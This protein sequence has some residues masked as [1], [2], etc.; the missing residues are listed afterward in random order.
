MNGKTQKK[1]RWR[2]YAKRTAWCL[3]T[4]I[5]LYNIL[6][7]SYAFVHW[8]LPG[9]SLLPGMSVSAREVKLHLFRSGNNL[10]IKDLRIIFDKDLSI[11]AAQLKARVDLWKLLHGEIEADEASLAHTTVVAA[12]YPEAL[13][14]ALAEDHTSNRLQVHS[15]RINELT[16]RYTPPGTTSYARLYIDELDMKKIQLDTENEFTFKSALVWHLQGSD[17]LRFPLN[18]KLFCRFGKDAVPVHMRAEIESEAPQGSLYDAELKDLRIR[19]SFE[20]E[21]AKDNPMRILLTNLDFGLWYLNTPVF[22]AKATGFYDLEHDD[23]AC[24]VSVAAKNDSPIF[25][26][27]IL[28]HQVLPSG[29]DLKGEASIEKHG[30]KLSAEASIDARADALSI[31]GKAVMGMAGLQARTSCSAN[32]RE[33]IFQVDKLELTGIGEGREN[34]KLNTE[35]AFVFRHPAEQSWILEANNA[36]LKFKITDFPLKT[37]NQLLPFDLE[38]GTFS[39]DYE[40]KADSTSQKV[41]GFFN[42]QALQVALRHEHGPLTRPAD[43]SFQSN[44]N[45]LGLNDIREFTIP[46]FRMVLTHDGQTVSEY[47][48]GG[49]YLFREKWIELD[50]NMTSKACLLLDLFRPKGFQAIRRKMENFCGREQ[51]N[52]YAVKMKVSIPDRKLDFSGTTHVG[53]PRVLGEKYRGQLIRIGYRGSAVF[54]TDFQ[55]IELEDFSVSLPGQLDLRLKTDAFFP[56][57]EYT[58]SF[59]LKEWRKGIT[60]SLIRVLEVDDPDMPELLRKLDFDNF[61]GHGSFRYNNAAGSLAIDTFDLALQLARGQRFHLYLKTPLAGDVKKRDFSPAAAALV[62]ENIP[63]TFCNI[64]I[65]EHT[66]FAM[67]GSPLNGAMIF[68]LAGDLSDLPFSADGFIENL[69][70]RKR[71]TEFRFGDVQITGNGVFRQNF[72]TFTYENALGTACGDGEK[73]LLIRSSAVQSLRAPYPSDYRLEVL[74]CNEKQLAVFWKDLPDFAALD[75]LDATGLVTIRSRNDNEDFDFDVDLDLKKIIFRFAEKKNETE[76]YQP[77]PFHGKLHL[78]TLLRGA[79]NELTLKNSDLKI[80][81]EKD[82]PVFQLGAD[83]SWV[84]DPQENRSVCKIRSDAAD[85]RLIHEILRGARAELKRKKKPTVEKPTSEKPAEEKPESAILWPFTGEEMAELDMAGFATRLDLELKNW[86]YTDRVKLGLQ[87]LFTAEN[88][89][90]RAESIRGELN[91]AEIQ[92]EASAAFGKQNLWELAGKASVTGLDIRP[93]PLVF[94]N[95]KVRK[96]EI[97][98]KIDRLEVEASTAGITLA[99]L[100]RNLKITALAELSGLSFPLTD[101]ENVQ[102]LSLLVLPAAII[103]R[104]IERLPDNAARAFLEKAM[105][106]YADILTGRKNLAITRGQIRLRSAPERHTDL[107]VE[108]CLLIGPAVRIRTDSGRINPFYN[109]VDLNT[110]TQFGAISYPIHLRGTIEHADVDYNEFFIGFFKHNPVNWLKSAATNLSFGIYDPDDANW[111]FDDPKPQSGPAPK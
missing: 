55:E 92:A 87:G 30:E 15:L 58:G 5:L 47:R 45:S 36:K 65:P 20:T 38:T 71:K 18:G 60:E 22:T 52:R 85:L 78:A 53:A 67:S 57:G 106:N 32:L 94:G 102:I 93:F 44:F 3:L 105:A 6:T 19:S 75:T 43:L 72:Q 91:G 77:G 12:R 13:R 7:S 16:V 29:L 54:R 59:E 95:E 9:L 40:L 84:R 104:L 17:Y 63:L 99:S 37:F 97:A 89:S 23:A 82:T 64:F 80:A 56:N 10:N 24:S 86:Q 103:P 66:N 73:N 88:N 98:G 108:K 31:D 70:F 28:K 26:G 21:S 46:E 76:K 35:G 25:S 2:T 81:D 96:K 49:R 1:P 11:T 34:L 48:L 27:T 107:L 90:F 61:T 100:D 68:K 8:Y 74:K 42:G 110:L 79:T 41:E 33:S 50:G 111:S 51:T 83:G 69:A 109:E 62:F 4:L 101:H 14:T 39:G